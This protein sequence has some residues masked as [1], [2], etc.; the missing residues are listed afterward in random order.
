M[1]SGL[2][3]DLAL[4]SSG[5]QES[6]SPAHTSRAVRLEPR[7]PWQGL[8]AAGGLRITEGTRCTRLYGCWQL[9]Q[10]VSEPKFSEK[11]GL[12]A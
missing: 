4:T 6:P 2:S 12:R 9:L 5:P 8:A 1:N 10:S 7:W 11:R 3:P